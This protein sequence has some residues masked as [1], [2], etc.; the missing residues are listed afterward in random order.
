MQLENVQ[1]VI[2]QISKKVWIN[3]YFNSN[4][5]YSIWIASLIQ[6]GMTACC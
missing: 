6:K 2:K 4:L 3:P 5:V 1:G